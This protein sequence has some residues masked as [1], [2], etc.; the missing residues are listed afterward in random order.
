MGISMLCLFKM[1]PFGYIIGM[2][3]K[4]FFKRIHIIIKT[5]KTPFYKYFG[6]SKSE[7]NGA[8]VL[9]SLMGIYVLTPLY[10]KKYNKSVNKN[11]KF[12]KRNS[13]KKYKRYHKTYSRHTS[14]INKKLNKNKTFLVANRININTASAYQIQKKC[15]F[16]LKLC[17]RIVA[18]RR[19]LKSYKNKKQFHKIYGI[20][21]EQLVV[22]KKYFYVEG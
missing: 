17:R 19:L 3:Y 9:V 14:K 6:F 15:E 16:D 13:F 21:K 18:Y 7:V 2:K 10:A 20:T 12:K 22:L 8:L 11:T 5:I 1:I 4:L